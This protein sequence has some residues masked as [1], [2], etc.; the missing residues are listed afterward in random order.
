EDCPD[1]GAFI[2]LLANQMKKVMSEANE[3]V[4]DQRIFDDLAVLSKGKIRLTPDTM[5][6][7]TY[8]VTS[9][10]GKKKKKK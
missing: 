1:K 5:V 10:T 8:K 3:D 9:N 6:L 2:E 7:R 4:D